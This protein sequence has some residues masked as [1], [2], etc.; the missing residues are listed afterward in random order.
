MS[1]VFFFTLV[2][3]SFSGVQKN[4]GTKHG[5]QTR[6]YQPK[7]YDQPGRNKSGEEGCRELTFARF[8]HNGC[9]KDNLLHR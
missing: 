6:L 9:S 1:N 7:Q 2:K 3:F 4:T 5:N 8:A